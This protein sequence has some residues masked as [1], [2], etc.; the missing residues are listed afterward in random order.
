MERHYD[1]II[2]GA[3]LAGLTLARQLLLY[4]DKTIL[5]LDREQKLPIA[6]QKL[7]ESNVQVAGHYLAKILDMEEHLIHEHVMKYNLRFMWKAAGTTGVN[8][9][10]YSHSYIRQFSNIP[11]YQLDRNKFE[12]ELIRRNQADARYLLL[13]NSKRLDVSLGEGESNHRMRFERLGECQEVT[14]RWLVDT[15]GRT[16]HLVRQLDSERESEILHS[17]TYFWVDGAVNVEKLTSASLQ[18]IRKR[19]ERC[20]LGHAP[21]WLA[22]NH[23]AGEG[24]WFWVIPLHTRTSFGLV[25]DN[26]CI[27]SRDVSTKDKMLTWLFRQ[28]PLFERELANREIIDFSVLRNYS[29]DCARTIHANRW[30]ISGFAGRFNDPLYSPGGDAIAIHNTL[31]T[32]AILTDDD[33]ELVAKSNAYEILMRTVYL[34]FLPSFQRSYNALGDQETFAMKYA[35]ELSIYFAFYVF[36][37]LNDLFCDRYFLVPYLRRFSQLGELN[38]SL[39]AFIAD[40][41]DWKKANR[42]KPERPIF[43]D[44]TEV[45][46]LRKAESTFYMIGGDTKAALR[47]LDCQLDSLRELARL[48]VAHVHAVVA[49]DLGLMTSRA[50]VEQIDLGKIQFSADEIRQRWCS[51]PKRVGDDFAWSIDAHVFRRRF[52]SEVPE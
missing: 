20:R 42:P 5:Q 6:R 35:W 1:I 34:S 40:Y 16:R 33:N 12:A 13:E 29:Y 38:R 49:G 23:F 50:H 24:F 52:H 37:F 48:C 18:E 26:R 2:V 19:P 25:Y 8:F 36:P 45:C 21:F 46:A 41:Y 30:A 51:V 3:G 28:F 9:E 7:G 39:L 32:D 11:A 27:D 4:T 44:F 15:S 22:T 43:F 47:E 10:D 17:A 31:I 14:C